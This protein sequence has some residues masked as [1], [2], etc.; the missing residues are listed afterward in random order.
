VFDCTSKG[1]LVLSSDQ[2][3]PI[4]GWFDVDGMIATLEDALNDSMKAGYEGLWATDD[5][6]WE[7]GPRRDFSKLVEYEHRLETFLQ[8]HRRMSGICQYHADTL[9]R[10]ALRQGAVTHPAIFINET[11]SRINPDYL[12]VIPSELDAQRILAE[13]NEDQP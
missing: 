8:Q 2:H 13:A 11:L 4:E 5:I 1:S 12:H 9:P 3:H 10:E 6:S 7:F